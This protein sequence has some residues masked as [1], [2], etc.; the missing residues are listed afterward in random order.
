MFFPLLSNDAQ[1]VP[2]GDDLFQKQKHVVTRHLGWTNATGGDRP[3]HHV[4][5]ALCDCWGLTCGDCVCAV[6]ASPCING[7]IGEVVTSGTTRK[8]GQSC[9]QFYCTPCYP[10]VV[11]DSCCS[12]TATNA[13]VG[14]ALGNDASSVA[15]IAQTSGT[16]MRLQLM[17][18]KQ[19]DDACLRTA[20][21]CCF[22]TPCHNAAIVRN[23]RPDGYGA[24]CPCVLHT[25]VEETTLTGDIVV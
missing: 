1:G 12:I 11:T 16:R 23:L 20:F 7:L 2:L 6:C 25:S 22:C 9:R 5:S 8:D 24:F 13:L 19:S 3:G 4:R 17:V 15:N 14:T 18:G 21:G 10:C